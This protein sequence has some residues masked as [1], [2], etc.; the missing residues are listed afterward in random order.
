MKN[1]RTLTISTG[2]NRDA[3]IWRPAKTTWSALVERLREPQRGTESHAGYMRMTKTQQDALKDVGGF[4][5]GT[6]RRGRRKINEVTGR[7]LITLDL[8]AIPA[9]GTDA[10][11]FDVDLLNCAACIYSTRK[12]DADHPR[13]RVLLPLSR[14]ITGEEYEPAARKAAEK[15]GIEKADPTCF[16]P[17]QM[18]YWPN[19]SSDSEYVYEVYDKPLMDPDALLGEYDDWHDARQWPQLPGAKAEAKPKGTKQQDPL[20]KEGVVGAFCRCYSITRAMDELLPGVYTPTDDPERFTYARGST[21]GGAIV[22]EDKWLYSHH[23]TDPCSGIEVN[24]WDLVRLHRFGERDESAK[25]GTPV[26]R[27]PSYAAMKDFALGLE[28]VKKDV[29]L[30]T[31]SPAEDFGA[32]ADDPNWF[33]KLELAKNGL[34]VMTARNLQ[35]I[36]HNDPALKGKFSYNQFRHTI[37]ANAALPWNDWA[38]CPRDWTDPDDAA[39]RNYF[40]LTYKICGNGKIGDMFTQIAMERRTDDVQDYLAGLEWDGVPRVDALLVKYLLAPDTPYVRA[41]T[42]KTLVAAVAR[43][44]DPG[45]K[46]DPV[47]TLVGAQGIAKSMLVGI[48]GGEWYNDSIQTFTGKEAQEQLRGSW[49]VEI[50]EVDRFSTKFDSAIVKQFITRQDDIFRESYGRRTSSHKRRCI[51]IATTNNPEFLVDATGNRRWWVV[52]C[53]ATSKHRG[54]DMEQL[55]RDRDQVWAEARALWQTGESLKL[56]QELEDAAAQLQQDAQQDDSWRGMITE[57]LDRPIPG[58]W[59]KRDLENRMLWWNVYCAES[60]HDELQRRTT[61]CIPEIWCECFKRDKGDLD[62]LKSRRIGGILRA[63]G[64]WE[65]VGPRPSGPYGN[66]KTFRRNA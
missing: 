55:R 61:V 6:L 29:L 24:A 37:T 16:R 62:P 9:G 11:L 26:N 49:L 27:L 31:I 25:E 34:P 12:H 17:N 63:L 47:L 35:L 30:Q 51:F 32:P 21:S 7:D 58:D 10:V 53:R 3:L 1:D 28:D 57:F 60:G 64:E 43:A 56:P 59:A 13:L 44:M 38:P 33:T 41:V 66:Q 20:E 48:L 65:P 8:D 40:D 22:Y 36:F 46:F 23:A 2:G 50:P 14:T 39:L 45:C 5:G 52:P 42:R 19:V 15:L 4:L 54:E 18:M